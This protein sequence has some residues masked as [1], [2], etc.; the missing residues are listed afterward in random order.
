MMKSFSLFGG[1]APRLRVAIRFAIVLVMSHVIAAG[2]SAAS[3]GETEV[4][5]LAG[6]GVTGF[7]DGPSARASFMLPMGLAYDRNGNLYVADG[8]AQ[9]IRLV[10]RNGMVTT[11]AGTGEPDQSGTWVP[12]GYADGDAAHARFNRPADV[13]VAQDGRIFV[14][15][16]YN[17]CIRVVSPNGIVSTFAGSPARSGHRSG[18]RDIAEFEGP[19]SLAFDRRGN[20]FVVDAGFL[21]EVDPSGTVS[22]VQIGGYIPYAGIALSENSQGTA[23]FLPILDGLYARRSDGHSEKFL[24]ARY[25]AQ[26][27]AKSAPGW[28]ACDDARTKRIR[29]HRDIGSPWG[30]VALNDHAIVYS[31]WKT[32]SIRLLDLRFDTQRL[33]AGYPLGDA[34]GRGG[35]H[36]DGPGPSATFNIPLGLALGPEK[37]IAIADAGSRRIR[38]MRGIDETEPPLVDGLSAVSGSRTIVYAGDTTAWQGTTWQDSIE[39]RLQDLLGGRARVVP[40]V[41]DPMWSDAEALSAV[42]ERRFDVLLL[43]LNMLDVASLAKITAAQAAASP[44]SWRPG[45]QAALSRLRAG[46][47]SSGAQLAVVLAP[48][49]RDVGPAAMLWARGLDTSYE[50][51]DETQV[52][53]RFIEGLG[54]PVVDATPSFLQAAGS[55]TP[56]PLF[57]TGEYEFAAGGRGAM[58]Q[59]ALAAVNRLRP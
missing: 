54:V 28:L 24:A 37:Q 33:L 46:V 2:C 31:D 47:A 51:S 50:T 39:G 30:V 9:R 7:A 10:D 44:R 42:R 55:R 19:T 8:A 29:E 4:A 23:Y 5:T 48:L 43:Q 21:R 14:A 27:V 58:A 13:A 26:C 16:T 6:S 40:L 3:S 49:P 57:A 22:T 59:A 52:L 34:S 38:V 17:H 25:A 36:V 20:L 18:P 12:G 32:G 35:G 15:D 56:P 45:L 41:L 53:R 1:S 11:V